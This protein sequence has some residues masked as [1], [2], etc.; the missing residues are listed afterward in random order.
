MILIN[1]KPKFYEKVIR[2]VIDADVFKCVRS[3]DTVDR[4]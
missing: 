2:I 1:L 4:P 3:K